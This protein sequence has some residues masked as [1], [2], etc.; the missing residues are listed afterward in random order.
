MRLTPGTRL[1]PYEVLASLGS[2][3]M[4]E[5]YRA[6]DTRLQREVAIK[7][8]GESLAGDAGFLSRLEQEA[9]L[10]GS[11]NHPNIVAVHDIG[12]YDGA[13][14]VVTELLQGETLRER[15]ARGPVPVGQALEWAGQIAH[16]LAAAHGLG[17]VHRD[18]KPENVFL[19]RTGQLKLLDFGIAKSTPRVT[20]ARGM[21]DPTVSPAGSATRT[22]AV[23]GTPGYMSPEQVRGENVDARSDIFSLGIILHELLSGQRTFRVGSIVESGY[24]ILHDEPAPLPPAVPPG[25][26]QVVQRCLAK[27]PEQ[28][29][30]SARDVAF[31]LEALRGTGTATPRDPLPPL[32]RARRR[33]LPLL[34]WAALGLVL[35]VAGYVAGRG[36]RPV[37]AEPLIREITFQRG[38]IYA[39]RFAPDGKTVHFSAAWSGGLPELYTT[40]S[41]SRVLRALGIGQAQLLSVSAAGS[42]AVMLHPHFPPGFGLRGTL[43][44][45]PQLGGT[46]RELATD[47]FYADWAPDGANLAVVRSGDEGVALEFPL[48]HPIFRSTGFVSDPRVSPAGDRVAFLDHPRAGDSAGRVTV[49]DKDGHV[50][51]WSPLYDD[52]FGLAWNRTGT[53]VVIGGASPGELTALWVARSGQDPRVLYRGTGN[54]LIQDVN[55][56]GRLLVS[57][58]DWRQELVVT[59]PD[60]PPQSVEWLDWA[61]VAGLSDD[62]KRILSFE[63]GV[64]AS[65]NLLVVLRNLDQPAP[66]QLGIGRALALSPD[67]RWAL[68]TGGTSDGGDPLVLLPTGPGEPRTLPTGLSRVYVASFFRDGKRVALLGARGEEAPRILVLDLET[69]AS[70]PIS[71]PMSPLFRMVTSLDQRWVARAD[72][73]GTPTLFPV[74]GGTPDR[75]TELGP[76]FEVIGWLKDGTLLLN[77]RNALPS[78]VVRFDLRTRQVSPYG[79]LAPGDLSGVPRVTKAM[80][81]PD[82]RTFAFHFRRRSDTLF[83]MDFGARA[84]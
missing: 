38:S 14:Y 2:G 60:A 63:S 53:E 42:L 11:L 5:V 18:L 62:G 37:H 32:G 61:S 84:P 39:A 21:L 81:T 35:A 79:V 16:A 67:G 49:A 13:P 8:V 25:V 23:L 44:I 72:A 3:G 59:R 19:T 57:Q 15:L 29:F 22:G 48:G 52:A 45:V 69:G 65:P 51:I 28:R 24:S 58:R 56:E 73:D 74:E 9:R 40:S 20:E 46:P 10:A 64:A 66:V 12:L 4:S 82:G 54:L 77:E 75:L 34:A 78:P 70:R 27:D 1:G 31:S 68:V 33:G 71:P 41:D 36:L 43:A 17:I 26:A 55:R 80:V 50:E 76:K 30:Q 6:R 83:L 7:V 47:V